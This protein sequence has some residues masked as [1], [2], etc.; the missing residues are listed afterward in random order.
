MMYLG[1]VPLA[2]F[3]VVALLVSAVLACV[4]FA[5]RRRRHLHLQRRLR[6]FR[7]TVIQGGKAEAAE[8]RLPIVER[9]PGADAKSGRS[10]VR[11]SVL[12]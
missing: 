10:E 9:E 6:V 12:P 2:T 5:E 8:A 7:P 1:Y 11:L 4:S 3:A